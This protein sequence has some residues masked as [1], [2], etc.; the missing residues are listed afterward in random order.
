[1]R[2]PFMPALLLSVLI[3]GSTAGEHPSLLGSE[4]R[5]WA[6]VAT[7][8]NRLHRPVMLVVTADECGYCLLLKNELLYSLDRYGDLAQ[9]VIIREMD[10]NSAGKVLD[11]EIGR[12]HV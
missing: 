9:R 4:T 3:G 5:D 6:E 2:I 11:F 7:L 1:M 8:A 10:L 12:A